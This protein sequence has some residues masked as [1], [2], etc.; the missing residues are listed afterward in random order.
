MRVGS[1]DVNT[2]LQSHRRV[3]GGKQQLQKIA[4]GVPP[5]TSDLCERRGTGGGTLWR[6]NVTAYSYNGG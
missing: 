2:I 3:A 4:L 5:P 6:R 1:A